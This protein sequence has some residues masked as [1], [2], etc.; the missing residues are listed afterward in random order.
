MLP[1]APLQ[2]ACSQVLRPGLLHDQS[3]DAPATL[4]AQIFIGQVQTG[5]NCVLSARA[6]ANRPLSIL[7]LIVSQ[8]LIR[9]VTSGA[10]K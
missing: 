5:W 8:P 10:V 3:G 9:G 7:Y 4:L 6:L 1:P 2:T